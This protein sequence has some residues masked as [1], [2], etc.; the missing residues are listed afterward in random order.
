MKEVL[1][2]SERNSASLKIHTIVL[3]ITFI[4]KHELQWE[5][6]YVCI[7]KKKTLVNKVQCLTLVLHF[8]RIFYWLW[9]KKLCLF[10]YLRIFLPKN[11]DSMRTLVN[12]IWKQKFIVNSQWKQGSVFDAGLD[13]LK[14]P[15]VESAPIYVGY[16]SDAYIGITHA[17]AAN[18]NYCRNKGN[19]LRGIVNLSVAA[20]IC[21]L[22]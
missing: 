13:L 14:A 8:H 10:F 12:S 1:F 6:W 15:K 7:W 5:T 19:L 22:P 4:T 11:W 16:K 18:S 21:Y 17:I 9:Q 2:I 3:K 20:L